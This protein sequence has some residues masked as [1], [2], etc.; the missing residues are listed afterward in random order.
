LSSFVNR[1][2]QSAQQLTAPLDI[3]AF[4]E[5]LDNDWRPPHEYLSLVKLEDARI[6]SG[7]DG[8]VARQPLK[9]TAPPLVLRVNCFPAHDQKIQIARFRGPPHRDR[10]EE[11]NCRGRNFPAGHLISQPLEQ[12]APECNE[13]LNRRRCQVLSVERVQ[14]SSADNLPR[15]YSLPHEPFSGATNALLRCV[16][17]QAVKFSSADLDLATGKHSQH[18]PVERRRDDA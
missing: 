6:I 10:A 7:P 16:A 11:H 4:R 13:R 9:L 15:H 8:R 2:F 5:C 3:D 18:I 14:A 1:P 17:D 12:L